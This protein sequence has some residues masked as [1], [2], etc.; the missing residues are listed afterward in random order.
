M[1]DKF[2]SASIL[3]FINKP[4]DAS[5]D[6]ENPEALV[7]SLIDGTRNSLFSYEISLETPPDDILL[8]ITGPDGTTVP[9]GKGVDGSPLN[10]P[11]II[12][13][14]DDAIF[15]QQIDL[16]QRPP[17][18]YTFTVRDDSDN[19]TLKEQQFY[20]DDELV[21]QSI[22]GIVDIVYSN[23]PGH[24]YGNTEEY[25]L[26]FS[27]KET[28][29]TYYI[30]NKNGFLAFDD[31]DLE[32][33]DPGSSDY[34][35]V[36]FSRVGDEPHAEIKINGFETVVFKSGVPIP[37]KDFPKPDLQLIKNP[38]GAVL[39]KNLPNPSHTG[40]VKEQNGQ[41]ESEIYVFI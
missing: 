16:R 5:D 31:H 28:V 6:P 3:Y 35:A 38:G 12:K 19:T 32:I 7:H 23:S 36:A 17:G 11:L 29:W 41:L 2:S 20:V 9:A 25:E 4:A 1:D 30:V 24:L 39:I 10:D 22:L 27:R 37:F 18:L 33:N 40:V 26:V 14:S 15:R 21:S 13:K 34:P 8:R